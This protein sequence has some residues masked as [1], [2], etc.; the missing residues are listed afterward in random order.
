LV[1]RDKVASAYNSGLGNAV[2]TPIIADGLT[3]AWAQY[4]IIVED[5]D[6]VQAKLK[7]H[8]VPSVVYYPKALTQ[9]DGY[10][11][12]PVVS[13]GVAISEDLARKVLSLPMHPYIHK[14]GLGLTI[15][16]VLGSLS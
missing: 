16:Q 13:S 4:T 14:E 12:F 7:E 3:S 5:R 1:A 10:S 2:T 8:G 6:A 15:D 11:S 9:Q